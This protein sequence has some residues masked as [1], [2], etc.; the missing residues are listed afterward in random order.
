ME[1]RNPLDATGV[2]PESY[3]AAEK[4]LSRQGFKPEDITGGNLTGLSLTI[5][6]YKQLADELGIG[7]ITLRDIVKELEKPARDPREEM[8]NERLK[9]RNDFKR[10][11]SECH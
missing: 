2:H 4:L 1:G 3:A 6:D 8:P 7:E 10:D 9:R 11:C 5:K